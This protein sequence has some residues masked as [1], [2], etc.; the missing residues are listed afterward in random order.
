MRTIL[1]QIVTLAGIFQQ[2][3]QFIA[4][5]NGD[6]PL[7]EADV[8]SENELVPYAANKLLLIVPADLP[9]NR[10]LAR[11]GKRLGTKR[12]RALAS[13]VTPETILRWYRRLTA[14]KYDGSQRRR[15]GRPRVMEQIRELVVRLAQENSTWGYTRIRGALRNVG[16]VVGR[17]TIKRILAERGIEPAPQRSERMPWKTFLKAHMGAIAATDFFTVEVWTSRGLVTHYVL[18][19][20]HHSTRAVHFAGVTTNPDSAFM[21]QVARNLTDCFDGFL[22]DKRYLILD[23]DSLFTAQFKRIPKDAGVKTVRTSYKAP[24]MNSIAELFVLSVKSECLNRMILFGCAHLE[25]C[26]AEYSTHYHE[27][28]PHQGLDNELITSRP[29]DE[30]TTGDVVVR[31]RLGGLIR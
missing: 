24:N 19:V 11:K 31:E 16:H 14:R 18:F 29:E 7:V 17:N 15:P 26:L 4:G 28:R 2:I 8:R 10:R 5:H 25:R 12:L 20:I 3:V 6:A 9:I 23:R 27:S 13:I 1:I 21:A 22:R 30:P